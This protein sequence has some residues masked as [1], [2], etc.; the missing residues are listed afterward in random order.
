MPLLLALWFRSLTV[1]TT[2]MHDKQVIQQLYA[3]WRL[4]V[5]PSMQQALLGAQKEHQ[6]YKQVRTYF[7]TWLVC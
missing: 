6:T 3:Q 1:P 4:P 5:S 7:D 2:I